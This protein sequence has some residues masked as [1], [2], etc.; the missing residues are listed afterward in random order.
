MPRYRVELL[1]TG[2]TQEFKSIP[3]LLKF[4]NE[5]R[6]SKN[7]R[8]VGPKGLKK[9]LSGNGVFENT[10]RI[11]KILKGD[12]ATSESNASVEVDH[13]EGE[14]SMLPPGGPPEKPL[15]FK[16]RRSNRKKAQEPVKTP[17]EAED[18]RIIEK[19][20]GESTPP[21]GDAMV[22]DA[23]QAPQ[24][25]KKLPMPKSRLVALARGRLTRKL[26]ALYKSVVST[27]PV[28]PN[29]R[30]QNYMSIKKE[31]NGVTTKGALAAMVMA[32][33]KQQVP[34]P[35][36]F[37]SMIVEDH[38]R[39]Q[40]ETGQKTGL[41]LEVAASITPEQLEK[42]VLEAKQESFVEG[43]QLVND[44]MF[45]QAQILQ[46]QL[47]ERQQEP[48][49]PSPEEEEAMKQEAADPE[50]VEALME[51][52]EKPLAKMNVASNL[53][54]AAGDLR[55]T[56][57]SQRQLL[58][59]IESGEGRLIK[60]IGLTETGK[61]KSSGE[62][63]GMTEASTKR[64]AADN[65][66]QYAVENREELLSVFSEREVENI[67]SMQ[68]SGP[69]DE[70]SP[71]ETDAEFKESAEEVLNARLSADSLN[72]TNPDLAE[73]YPLSNYNLQNLGRNTVASY[74]DLRAKL[75]TV[76]LAPEFIGMLRTFALNAFNK[77]HVASAI[78]SSLLEVAQ[79]YK[80]TPHMY[81]KYVVHLFFFVLKNKVQIPSGE[82]GKIEAGLSQK[83]QQ[84]YG[85]QGEV[86]DN[87]IV[88]H[89]RLMVNEA[90]GTPVEVQ[91]MVEQE[92]LRGAGQLDSIEKGIVGEITRTTD[93]M[94]LEQEMVARRRMH[95]SKRRGMVLYE[96]G[97]S[98][99]ATQAR[100]APFKPPIDP[101]LRRP[102]SEHLA[103]TQSVSRTPRISV[104]NVGAPQRVSVP[105]VVPTLV[106]DERPIAFTGVDGAEK[107]LMRSKNLN[108]VNRVSMELARKLGTS[109]IALLP[110]Q[111]MQQMYPPKQEPSTMDAQE[112]L[113]SV[114]EGEEEEESKMDGNGSAMNQTELRRRRGITLFSDDKHER[115]A[116]K[117]LR[118]SFTLNMH[119]EV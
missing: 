23:E 86:E 89:I 31:M 114:P 41:N 77:Q 45:S 68:G 30:L 67:A 1:S 108:T 63:V 117:R 44:M 65:M 34:N 113:P 15:P 40:E 79:S 3:A 25:K 106:G 4:I 87:S 50:E 48:E 92:L 111:Q 28:D 115:R 82:L 118:A 73:L 51:E 22:L 75:N 24:A 33:K 55:N 81:A 119:T 27:R 38:K 78:Q 76:Q 102:L 109:G 59:N 112:G 54:K 49:A 66:K 12:K 95:L 93:N 14:P 72:P 7:K 2:D 8:N 32:A 70:K 71:M 90:A 116:H 17:L 105:Q 19:L 16:K 85:Q 83:Y 98:N 18:T 69:E 97:K 100:L 35:T 94:L 99:L 46:E 110:A 96:P 58:A 62:V 36:Q 107:D 56:E 47:Q 42:A 11:R 5:H 29:T 103:P 101:E 20:P 88:S 57:A 52:E 84:F 60:N 74:H 39:V 43:A 9:I 6:G 64:D 26:G 21:K 10:L 53:L 80:A 13:S 61:L 104:N 37:I 91:P